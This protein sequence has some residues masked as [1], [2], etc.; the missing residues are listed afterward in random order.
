MSFPIR[1]VV[2]VIMFGLALSLGVCEFGGTALVNAKENEKEKTKEKAKE[3]EK[4][5]SDT[6]KEDAKKEAEKEKTDA[7]DLSMELDVLQRSPPLESDSRAT[8]ATA[9]PR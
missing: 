3:K 4:N 7:N 2:L 5:G 1:G 6:K 9:G 8:E